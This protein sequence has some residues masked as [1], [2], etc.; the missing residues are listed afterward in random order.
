MPTP[1]TGTA[2]R[3]LAATRRSAPLIDTQSNTLYAAQVRQHGRRVGLE[4]E[5]FARLAP[6][7]AVA[8]ARGTE[9]LGGDAPDRWVRSSEYYGT[10]AKWKRTGDARLVPAGA[11]V[12]TWKAAY[13]T[14]QRAMT[15]AER[16]AAARG[17]PRTALNSAYARRRAEVA[18]MGVG[19]RRVEPER[20]GFG[21]VDGGP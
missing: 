7:T 15:W 18:S 6:G 9:P 16:S 21:L 19:R 20:T 4:H 2:V 12:A 8:V 14:P 11:E 10:S 5:S 3:S 17:D 13:P 1:S